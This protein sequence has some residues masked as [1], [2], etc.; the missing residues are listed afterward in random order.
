[1]RIRSAAL[2][3]LL[4]ATVAPPAAA[5][6]PPITAKAAPSTAPA[7]SGPGSPARPLPLSAQPNHGLPAGQRV[8][9]E[10]PGT[11]ASGPART[12]SAKDFAAVP[13]PAAKAKA[14]ELLLRSGYAAGDT[15][16]VL[17]FD[18]ADTAVTS[19][20]ATV[21]DAGTRAAQQS[22]TLGPGDLAGC[23][24]PR[25]N[26]RG[27]GGAEG[28]AL[29]A[30]HD[31]FA[32]ITATYPDGSTV[33]SPPSNTA[34]PRT[35]ADS[36]AVP[37][38]QAV[39]CAC[40][41]ALGRTTSGQ[42]LR[43]SGVNTGTGAYT[44]TESDL[45]MSS[46]AVPFALN[47]V[48]SSANTTAGLFGTGWA[49]TLDLRVTATPAGAT[50]RAEDG[51]QAD[52]TAAD[53]GSFG[54]PAGVRSDLKKT[55]DGWELT[56][57]E[58]VHYRFD[59]GGRLTAVRNARG[60]GL[61][62]SYYGSALTSV[63]D[64]AGRKVTVETRTDLGLIRK[65]SLPD[66]RATQF[67]YEGGRLRSVQAATGQTSQYRYDNGRLSQV[68][69]ARGQVQLT[70]TYN[71]TTGRVEQQRDVFGKVTTVAW[72]EAR[73]EAKVTDPDGVVDTDGYAGNLL[74]YSQNG[75]GD[76]ASQR[77]DERANPV[78]NVDGNGNQHATGFDTA[79]NP[80]SQQAPEPLG[81]GTAAAYQAGNRPTRYTDGRGNTWN[82]EYN[83][84]HEVTKRTDA[85]NHSH[86]Y[87][88]DDRGLLRSQTDPRGKV[89]RYEYDAA[90]NHTAIVAPTG[91]RTQYGYDGTGRRT[92]MTDPR[93]YLTKYTSDQLD[94]PK[95][96]QDPDKGQ[97]WRTDYDEVGHLAV[98]TDPLS[99][100][101]R[102]DYDAAGRL[103]TV[104]SP[105]GRLTT[106]GYTAA[107]RLA[108]V[109]DGVGNKT[110]YAYSTKGLLE[111][112][113]TPRGNVAGA[114]AAAYTWTFHYDANDNPV[115][116]THP[117]PGGGTVTRD[118]SWDELN[119]AIGDIDELGKQTTSGFDNADNVTSVTD[120]VSSAVSLTYDKAN[121]PT[122]SIDPRG[123]VTRVEHDEAGNV[124]KQTTA[125]GGV[126]TFTY[127]DD[128]R[129]LSSVEPRGNVAGADA[130]AYRTRYAYDLA[131][132]LSTVTDP[133]GHVTK[134]AYDA[135]NR[136]TTM[137]DAKGHVTTWR[138]DDADRTVA[139]R[140]P[141]ATSDQQAT[142]YDYDADSLV[143]AVH[144]ANR[145]TR[146]ML[147][148]V[149]GRLVATTDDLGRFREYAY[150]PDGNLTET[151]TARTVADPRNPGRDPDRAQRTITDTFDSLSRLTQ[152]KLGTSGPAYT[153]GYDAK[154]RLTAANDP[155]GGYTADYDDAGRP[156]RIA[157]G[158]RA[159]G[160]GYDAAGN[161]TSRRYPDGTALTA[162][163]DDD[164]RVTELAGP[165]GTWAF[166]YDPAGRRVRTDLPA[167]DLRENRDYD[168]SGRLTGVSTTTAAGGPSGTIG[169]FALALD[170]VGNTN[171]ITTTRG[172]VSEQVAYAY[173]AADRLT[174]ACYAT[175]SC[176]SGGTGRI[177]Y[178]YDPVGNRTSQARSGSAGSGT[179]TYRYDVV[180][181]LL[182]ET[183]GSA[184]KT[185]KYDLEGN[186]LDAG[187]D[188]F[189]YHLDHTLLS[190]TVGGTTT[191]YDYDANGLRL[192]SATGA[193]TRTFE[194]DP[195]G[196]LPQIA[197]DRSGADSR[198]F[199]YL[200][201]GASAALTAGGA[202]H[203]YVHDWLGGTSAMVAGSG[204]VESVLD[205]DP[206]G[207]ERTSPTRAGV[208]VT[209]DAAATANP[210]RFTGQYSDPTLG[211]DYYQ[212][213]R[214]YSP[215]TGR[216][217]GVDPVRSGVG[218][219][220]VSPY[221]YVANRPTV[222][223]DPSGLLLDDLLDTVEEKASDIGD[224]ISG[225]VDKAASATEDVA[226]EAK[227]WGEETL[228]GIEDTAHDL[229]TAAGTSF[230]KADRDPGRRSAARN[231]L[232]ERATTLL[233]DEKL[234][235]AIEAEYAEDEGNPI[236]QGT[237]ATLDIASLLI[238][239]ESTAAR[240]GARN[241][242][243]AGR[244]E[245]VAGRDAAMAVRES[246]AGS[247]RSLGTA[248]LG[249]SFTGG[250][251]VKL[252]DGSTKPISEIRIGDK[253]AAAD[254]ATATAGGRTVTA[255]IA[256]EG[257][258]HLVDVTVEADGADATVTATDGHPFWVEDTR[259]WTAAKDLRTGQRVR[260]DTGAAVTIVAL[261]PY[262]ERERVYN[263]S[264][265]GLHTYH[266]LA[267]KTPVLVH[268]CSTA[269]RSVRA[270]VAQMKSAMS[271]G[272]AGR[273]TYAAA[274]V[275][276]AGGKPELWVAG[277]GRDGRV[278]RAVRGNGKAINVKS[279]APPDQ[280]HLPH[281]ND[282]E[283]HL[284][285]AAQ[286]R[287][288]T[289]NAIGATRPVCG[290]C[291]SRL[292]DDIVIVTELK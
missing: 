57:P 238:G 114:D 177:D 193:A 239:G 74:Q 68:V 180:D 16:L 168:R 169:A 94:R 119:R 288:A 248:C 133:L 222:A 211:G 5:A 24:T 45:A 29:D 121:R 27:F 261:R 127:D 278:P 209:P 93:G 241:T 243:T 33:T 115:R 37:A 103:T 123:N 214:V 82:V 200:P 218:E 137:T 26:C 240:A 20:T 276:T 21:F 173:D 100:N 236:R 136:T 189:S 204:A 48:Y 132:N 62:L 150:D 255:L 215:S 185:Y 176:S 129:L 277:A 80:T 63:T 4:A 244:A 135:T 229:D 73:Q 275:T 156:T 55:A 228:Q 263:L 42:K 47:R 280:A 65:V 171:S 102:F 118:T 88:Y 230:D 287:G 191:T 120:P 258:K 237:R 217:T 15:S 75:N 279:P 274:H 269:I 186:Q 96:Q 84:F 247:S 162:A 249:N 78:L 224:A 181:Q 11:R 199:T 167:G 22:V 289:I 91:R 219:P 260:T 285:R 206:F 43:G 39:G 251:E 227:E 210:L 284:Y 140:G 152:R 231:R 34:S 174:S 145:H 9:V 160:Y 267:G 273:T 92:S 36:P 178:R 8:P 148:D 30:G 53:D 112:L 270:K 14:G 95:T 286:A 81:F 40:P 131:G 197:I 232:K 195:V 196:P 52:Y 190:A 192:T 147:Y 10:P 220:S 254:P 6:A 134:F 290:W 194:W 67:D 12:L 268:N 59:G 266:V 111:K 188:R 19:W 35:L 281:I 104:K 18:L 256:G 38:A 203:Y 163:Y 60:L 41:N 61:T 110:T 71:G 113:V 3:A 233:D 272:E 138:Y 226:S 149:A 83:E 7:P 69:D 265:D 175:P 109:T 165:A 125:T 262:T 202:H 253:V 146:S 13:K 144:D 105:V 179:T 157:R 128:G 76:S 64:A 159:F 282:A 87:A 70:N 50:V 1:M 23:G 166:H 170:A 182:S 56:T 141:D 143:T 291:Q 106:Y 86:S 151:V 32:Q 126:T 98:Q 164:N 90:G 28:W 72:D 99:H 117:N 221:A 155:S 101:T 259:R 213:A 49:S 183:T 271:Q 153:Y 292:P 205:Y 264:V 124:V 257:E 161:V 46:F 17:Y 107:G 139:V 187:A 89:T 242:A 77:Y 235:S 58:Q 158:D 25:R 85:E 116:R 108:S 44:R 184:T 54:K 122:T 79:G 2:A 252:A 207:V 223:V 198:T 97:P 130:D 225:A 51:A 142:T 154:D 66:G 201:D 245:A 283:M 212:R 246:A 234:K 250:T 31:Y 208:T 216:F 172:G